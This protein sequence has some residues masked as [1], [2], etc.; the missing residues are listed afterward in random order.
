MA[1]FFKYINTLNCLAAEIQITRETIAVQ[2]LPHD[3]L[4]CKARSCGDRM[5]SVRL[6]VTLM[7]CDDIGWNFLKIISPL[8]SL[9]CSLFATT[10]K[11][12]NITGLLQGEHPKFFAQIGVGCCKS[13]CRR[14]IQVYLLY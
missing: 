11:K 4:Q 10:T 7:D 1:V 9:G 12:A 8:V 13:G 5:S 14:M 6:S 3:A 2:F